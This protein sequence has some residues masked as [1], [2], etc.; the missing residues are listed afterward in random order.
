METQK[1]KVTPIGWISIV[2]GILIILLG[3]VM[4]GHILVIAVGLGFFLL[5]AFSSRLRV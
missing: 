5:G 4:G 3:S 2:F 1:T